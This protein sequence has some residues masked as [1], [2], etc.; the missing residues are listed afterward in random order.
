MLIRWISVSP[1]PIAMG[2]KPRGARPSVAPRMIKR[3]MKVMTTSDIK[4]AISEYPNTDVRERGRQDGTATPPEH[5]P[6][7][8]DQ[9]CCEALRKWHLVPPREIKPMPTWTNSVRI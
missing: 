3:N 4:Q 5:Q 8:A 7:G 6:A 2:A 9:L 1:S